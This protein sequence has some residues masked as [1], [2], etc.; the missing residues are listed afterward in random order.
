MARPK[1]I[2]EKA[3]NSFTETPEIFRLGEMV[4]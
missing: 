4:T 1:K 3:N 2:V